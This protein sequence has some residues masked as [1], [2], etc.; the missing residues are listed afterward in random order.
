MPSASGA[1]ALLFRRATCVP[2][3]IPAF[4]RALQPFILSLLL[5]AIAALPVTRLSLLLLFRPGE[6]VAALT[7]KKKIKEWKKRAESQTRDAD[8]VFCFEIL[9]RVSRSF[10]IVIEELGDELRNAVCVFY[11]VLRGLD[12]VSS[13]VE[14]PSTLLTPRIHA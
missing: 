3:S 5:L 6:L 13:R 2:S 7:L 12:T 4:V 9:N 8:W 14:P 11:L 10:A 1:L